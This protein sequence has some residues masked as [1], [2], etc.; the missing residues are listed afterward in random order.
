MTGAVPVPAKGQ[1]MWASWAAAVAERVNSLCAMAPAGML[2]RDGVGGSGA[3]P[4]PQN[5]RNLRTTVKD[6]SCFRLS[7][8]D[9]EVEEEGA[10]AE[11]TT[12]VHRFVVDCY[13]NGGGITKRV[14]NTDI[15]SL[16]PVPPPTPNPSSTP[17]PQPTPD[18]S[19]TTEED[20]TSDDHGNTVIYFKISADG[21][22][23]FDKCT[24]GE[25][26]Q[27]QSGSM[28]YVFPLYLFDANGALVCDLRTAPHIQLFDVGLTADHGGDS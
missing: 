4:L 5:L 22:T 2:A 14:D 6:I 8:G 12:E 28:S 3:Q 20:D 11:P 17:D 15:E 16:I 23:T 9:V 7:S 27:L 13:Y 18:P 21:S 25:L 10:G 19:S 26:N 1:H 24:F